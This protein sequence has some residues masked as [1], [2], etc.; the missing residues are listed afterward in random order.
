M[1]F[2]VMGEEYALAK[3]GAQLFGTLDIMSTIVEGVRLA[4]GI[5]NSTDKSISA[6]FC[7]GERVLVCSN[8]AFHSEIQIAAK[9]STNVEKR[10]NER[11]LMAVASLR[12]YCTAAQ[13]RIEQMRGRILDRNE[14]DSIILRA[15]EK[16][17]VK[18]R[19][20]PKLIEEWREPSHEVF[21]TRTAWSLFNCYTEIL[22][23]RQR[24]QPFSAAQETMAFQHLLCS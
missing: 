23:D 13:A 3:E 15:F 21:E 2:I 1:G 24:E 10:L 14:A 11:V 4:V 16:R 5:A 8:L 18:A 9:H 6:K 22:K 7:A 12:P 20:L 19:S 17:I